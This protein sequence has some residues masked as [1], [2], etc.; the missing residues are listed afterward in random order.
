M[1]EELKSGIIPSTEPSV[2]TAGLRSDIREVNGIP[3]VSLMSS[4]SAEADVWL[5]E[6]ADGS[7]VAVKIYRHG[8]IPGL[9]DVRKKCGLAHSSLVPV[10][11]AGQVEDRYYEVSPFIDGPTLNRFLADHGPLGESEVA[12]ILRQLGGAIHYL[13][14]EQVLH[15]DVKPSNVFVT[16]RQPLA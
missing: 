10:L 12:E 15:R 1:S 6:Q 16:G 13:H 9:L 11:D 2:S 3:L 5:G 7:R 4:S 8:Q 14:T